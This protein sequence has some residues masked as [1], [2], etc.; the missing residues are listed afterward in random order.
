[1]VIDG[2]ARALLD[3]ESYD[4]RFRESDT[5]RS[6]DVSSPRRDLMTID[7][8]INFEPRHMCGTKFTQFTVLQNVFRSNNWED[9]QVCTAAVFNRPFVMLLRFY[10]M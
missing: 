9:M 5:M 6:I 7:G 4:S 10:V 2:F 3:R 8:Q 1:M